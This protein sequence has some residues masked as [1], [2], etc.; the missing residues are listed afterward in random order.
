ME[1]GQRMDSFWSSTKQ[2]TYHN[3]VRDLNHDR[4]GTHYIRKTHTS[5]KQKYP[6]GS[7]FSTLSS[8]TENSLSFSGLVI[9]NGWL[10]HKVW[11]SHG[12]EYKNYGLLEWDAVYSCRNVRV[13]R[14][15]C[16]LHLQH[17]R[18]TLPLARLAWKYGQRFPLKGLW[19]STR[20]YYD[21]FQKTV[22][23]ITEI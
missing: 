21:L 12:R 19:H 1:N 5:Q 17:I 20:L 22:K 18:R 7:Y 16:F 11:D 6:I 15:T 3:T 23:S 14:R 9:C 2:E 13:M 4:L 8:Q 10:L